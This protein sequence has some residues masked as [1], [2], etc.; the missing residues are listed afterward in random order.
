MGCWPSWPSSMASELHMAK[1][2]W[3]DIN[4][5]RIVPATAADMDVIGELADGRYKIGITRPRS[6]RHNGYYWS[7]LSQYIQTSG[8]DPVPTKE[9]LHDHLLMAVGHFEWVRNPFDGV[10]TKRPMSTAFDSM[11][12][13]E[14]GNYVKLAQKLTCEFYGFDAWLTPQEINGLGGTSCG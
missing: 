9:L 3:V 6:T 14:F 13:I 1:V 7:S 5:G 8:A 12:E 2:A 11:D 4:N 10:E